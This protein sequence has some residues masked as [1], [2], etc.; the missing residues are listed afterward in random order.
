MS[1]DR[2]MAF[3]FLMDENMQLEIEVSM[4]SDLIPGYEDLLGN[5]RTE[6]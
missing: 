1:K 6:G 2:Q 5:Q 3:P 4:R